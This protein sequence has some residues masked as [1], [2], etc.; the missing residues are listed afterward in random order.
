MQEIYKAAGIDQKRLCFWIKDNQ[1]PVPKVAF[2]KATELCLYGT[3]GSPY[4]SDK[5][6]NLN[7]ALN[8]EL[9]TGARL[10][11]DIM[12]LF[13][14]WLAKRLPTSQYEHPTEKPPTLYEKALR[15][16]SK[17]GDAILDM[18]AGSG[19]LMVACHQ[20]KR[21]AYLVEIEPIFCQLILNRYERLTN[22][23]PKKIS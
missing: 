13:N 7:E 20:L 8:K 18:T 14:I 1:N 21:A 3:R 19:S 22:E 10:L 16:C 5:I 15:R 9:T 23:K 17:P 6:K 12:D 4:L 2:N 11:D